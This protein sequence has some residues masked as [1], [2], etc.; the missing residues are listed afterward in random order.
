MSLFCVCIPYV[1]TNL[2]TVSKC[3]QH[4]QYQVRKNHFPVHLD[5]YRIGTLVVIL[6]DR[7]LKPGSYMGKETEFIF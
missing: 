1:F 4:L 6:K 5:I 2:I 3:L 7:L